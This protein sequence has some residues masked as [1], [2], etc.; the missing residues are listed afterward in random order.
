MARRPSV[1]ELIISRK[2]AKPSGPYSHAVK[3]TSPGETLYISGMLPV[4]GMGKP[5]QGEMKKQAEAALTH[6]KNILADAKFTMD[7][8]TRCTVY[9]TDLSALDAIDQVYQRM[10]VGQTL[11]ARTVVQVAALPQGAAISVDAIAV[12]RANADSEES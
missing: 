6:V 9:V 4:D 3:V 7:D 5:V 10:F 11:P 12:K 2:V 1:H 8:V